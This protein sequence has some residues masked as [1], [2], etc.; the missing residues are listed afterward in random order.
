[1][2]NKLFKKF[3]ISVLLCFITVIPVHADTDGTE[4]QIAQQPEQLVL[5]LGSNWSG[6][7][8]TLKTDAGVFPAPIK[9]DDTGV[10]RM[11]LGGSKTYTLSC[12]D[13]TLPIPQPEDSLNMP[14]DEEVKGNTDL[15]QETASNKK[16]PVIFFILAGI[17][18]IGIG[19]GVSYLLVSRAY[20]YED[21]EGNYDE[22]SEDI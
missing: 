19:A 16:T 9:V 17:F 13:S 11:D 4:I 6:V 7:E 3:F 2:R 21:Y 8:F 18:L 1:M 12:L 10:L 5:Q 20:E 14:V 22:D 15:E